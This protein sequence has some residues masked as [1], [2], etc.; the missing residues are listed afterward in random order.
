MTRAWKPGRVNL[1][2]LTTLLVTAGLLGVAAVAGHFV[3]KRMIA[4]AALA[5]GRAACDQ[6]DWQTACKQLRR[7]LSKYPDDTDV[8]QQYAEAHLSVRPLDPSRIAAAIGAYR[9]LLRREPHAEIAYKRLAALYRATGNFNELAYVAEQL[10]KH[11]PDDPRAAIWLASARIAQQDSDEAKTTL[12][13]L[14]NRL[15]TQEE[16]RAEY[17]EACILLSY[18]AAQGEPDAARNEAFAWLDKAVEYDPD[19]ARAL[20]QRARLYRARAAPLDQARTRETDLAAARKDLERAAALKPADP[21]IR[22]ALSEEWMEHG[23][24]DRATADLDAVADVDAAAL[25]EYFLDPDDWQVL[26]FGQAAELAIRRGAIDEG[27]RLADETLSPHDPQ[28]AT[29]KHL[30]HRVGALPSGIGLYVLGGKVGKARLC[31]NEYLDAVASVKLTPEREAELALLRAN[32]ARASAEPYEVIDVLDPIVARNP[33]LPGAWKLLAEAFRR[34]DQPRRAVQALIEYLRLRPAD[35]EMTLQLAR[36]YRELGDWRRALDAARLAQ[37]MR[38]TDVRVSLLRLEAG[39]RVASEQS[40]TAARASI[41]AL[42]AELAALRESHPDKVEIRLLQAMIAAHQ[43]H[44]DVAEQELKRAITECSETLPAELQL[45]RFYYRTG[46][47]A[48]ALEVAY[49]AC[50]GHAN[51]AEPWA[52][53]SELQRASEQYAEARKT[54]QAGLAAVE[55]SSERRDLA[56]GLALFDILHD[57]RQSG[58][59]L[60][61]E[62]A[63]E[64]KRDLRVAA[65]LL[66]LPEVRRD[67]GYAQQLVDGLREV[68]RQSGLRWRMYQ[69]AVWLSGQEWRAKQQKILELL[70]HCMTADPQWP[71]PALLLGYMYERLGDPGHAQEVYRRT[72]QQNPTAADVA[73]RLVTLLE[74]EQQFPEARETLDRLEI[75]R[76]AVA[77][78]RVIVAIRAGDFAQA[79]DDLKLRVANDPDDAGAR[80]VLARLLYLQAQDSQAAFRYLDE[81][82]ALAPDSL[83]LTAVRVW[84]LKAE[85][86]R[87]EARRLLDQL[88]AEEDTFGAYLLRAGYFADIGEFE[89]AEQDYTELIRFQNNGQGYRLL[90]QFHLNANRLS[91]AIT[92]WEK[93]C[94]AYPDNMALKRDL[95]KALFSR[96]QRDD[97]QRAEAM[98]AE[99]T[100]RLPDDPDLLWVRAVL[101]LSE[102]TEA[103]TTEAERLLERVV[104]QERTHVDAHLLLIGIAMNRGDPAE[105]RDLAITALGTNRGNP[106]LLLARAEAERALKSPRT[107]WELARLVLGD[108]PENADAPRVLVSAALDADKLTSGQPLEMLRETLSLLTDAIARRPEDEALRLGLANTLNALGQTGAAI[109]KLEAYRQANEAHNSL[110]VLLTLADLYRVRGDLDTSRQRIEAAAALAP[111][112]RA[113]LQTRIKWLGD[114]Q[115]FDQVATLASDYR[116]THPD[117]VDVFVT[118]AATL[119]TSDEQQQRRQAR[120]LLEHVVVIA[121]RLTGALHAL[122][123]LAYEDGD[124]ARAEECF[125][126]ILAEDP[127]NVAALNDLAWILAEV[128]ADDRAALEEALELANRAVQLAPDNTYHLDTRGVILSRFPARLRDARADLERGLR[129]TAEG[130]PERRAK[131]LLR[132]AQVCTKLGESADVRRYLNEADQIDQR[133]NVFTGDERRELNEL[134]QDVN[135]EAAQMTP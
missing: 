7:Y 118:A 135:R 69:A 13:V 115:Q 122:A 34:T 37:S 104:Q 41:E 91:R 36:G 59:D 112:S 96:A 75:D 102:D 40:E 63:A 95:M 30:P 22:L 85:D 18:I 15:E 92:A 42:S 123:R 58:T 103:A 74:K 46:R 125:R 14:L 98:L 62:M 105:A 49:A 26:I 67:E 57:D 19:S 12:A 89:L 53:M 79:I 8:L 94:Q 124:A 73:E 86:Q 65:L 106:R 27:V 93:G 56:I 51:V 28:R 126:A 131:T 38:P 113:V 70:S 21:R 23:E 130:S 44:P 101:T 45:A 107:A 108:D 119:A 110:D 128:R 31:L 52:T 39:V 55:D 9:R 132:L 3:R 82:E 97:R 61:K 2:L 78:R 77:A 50:E 25:R 114:G 76:R 10:S 4:D 133:H 6:Q 99:L 116:A 129:L 80:I 32:V 90:G 43:G 54:L 33:S 16:K 68:E 87:E 60:L 1:K 11:D 17:V 134:L 20:V 121:P 117:D 111:D 35:S 72:L 88:V 83:A 100:E 47:M 64:D 127:A 120:E 84:I 81:A 109:E 5:A 48:E 24:Y 66:E 71:V 29:L